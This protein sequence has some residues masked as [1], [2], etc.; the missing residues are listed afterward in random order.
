MNP[1]KALAR[2][3]GRSRAELTERAAQFLASRAER[4]GWR[5]TREPTVAELN[6][7]LRQPQHGGYASLDEWHAHFQRGE[8]APFFPGLADR[9]STVAA[10]RE[11]VPDAEGALLARAERMLHGAFDLLGY[12]GLHYP[13]PI[14]WHL[15][16]V[17]GRRAPD[18]HWSVIR[19][20]D[21]EVCG[22]HKAIWEINRHQVLVT[23]GQAYWY[24]GDERFATRA[25]QWLHEWMDA[26]PPKHGINWASSLEVAFRANSW[27][28]TLQLLRRSPSLDTALFARVVGH[29]TLSAR[30]LERFLSTYFSPNTHLTGEALGLYELGLQLSPLADAERWRARGM[31]I[32]LEELPRHVHPDGVYFEQATYYQR[33]TAEFYL[34]VFILSDETDGVRDRIRAPL[35]KL[36]EAL[37][38]TT[39]P[40][41]TIPLIGDDDGGRLM[42]FDAAGGHDVRGLLGAAA[43]MLNRPDFA[44]AANGI[45]PELIWLLGAGGATQWRALTP[46]PPAL[47]SRAFMHGGL[48]VMRDGWSPDASSMVIDAGPHGVFNCG[49]AHADALAFDLTVGG[50]AT[51]VDPGTFTYTAPPADRDLFRSTAVHN[52]LTVNDTSSSLMQGPF[53]WTTIANASIERWHSA[54]MLDF[55]E[56]SHDGYERPSVHAEVVRSIVFVKDGY[57]VVRDRVV[58]GRRFSAFATLQCAIGFDA[59]VVSPSQVTVTDGAHPLV[60]VHGVGEGTSMS[61][62]E[63]WV[64]PG[65]GAREHAPRIRVHVQGAGAVAFETVI[66][67]ASLAATVARRRGTASDII[68]VRTGPF[69]DALVFCDGGEHPECEGVSTDAD[70]FWIR[71][72]AESGAPVACFAT[73]ATRLTVDGT[74]VDSLAMPG[75]MA[76]ILTPAGWQRRLVGASS[77]TTA[78]GRSLGDDGDDAMP[79]GAGGFLNSTA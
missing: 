40:D 19:F 15:D 8:S 42:F 22:D 44:F 49:H 72:D 1:L 58:S 70:V 25:A 30:H 78:P 45:R 50:R 36:L 23:L 16:P 2:L 62:D 55:F 26:N 75:A 7:R 11:S 79:F 64:S 13:L 43:V 31:Q 17:R 65:Y 4:L 20:L 48:L 74:V 3:R 76:A 52:A 6:R 37:Q 18:G 67:K 77:R 69:R 14:D 63:G 28:W 12:R 59:R 38:S 60:V 32:L 73:G 27:L 35:L 29:L 21:D 71:R 46:V 68:E 10:L 66:A 56:G 53:S 41:G 57:W 51:F 54:P 5:D 47:G 34:H 33:Y 61:I 39:R 9:D 24:S